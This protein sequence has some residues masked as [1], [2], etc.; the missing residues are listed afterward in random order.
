[1]RCSTA[2]RYINLQLD[3]EI[4]PEPQHRLK[5]HLAKCPACRS[6]QAEELRLYQLLSAKPVPEMPA[7]IHARIM[8][9]VHRLDAKRSNFAHKFRLATAGVA[10]AVLISA[11]GGMEIGIKSFGDAN[12]PQDN[13]VATVSSAFGE[14]TILESYLVIG[15]IYE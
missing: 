9:S 7:W 2:K 3:G 12:S 4:K 15:D 10:I 14:N 13:S 8:D 11:W 1:M 5:Q 6:W